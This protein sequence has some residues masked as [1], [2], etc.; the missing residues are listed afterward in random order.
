MELAPSLSVCLP[1]SLVTKIRAVTRIQRLIKAFMVTLREGCMQSPKTI[2]Y[3]VITLELALLVL[4]S[5]G[6]N[7]ETFCSRASKWGDIS[8]HWT[9]IEIATAS[10]G[11]IPHSIATIGNLPIARN[12]S[13]ILDPVYWIQYWL[14]ITVQLLAAT[15]VFHFILQIHKFTYAFQLTDKLV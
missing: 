7:G 6:M 10:I 3:L 15:I 8:L 5:R 12:W 1:L 14:H 13:S 9:I 4:Y 11:N 2:W